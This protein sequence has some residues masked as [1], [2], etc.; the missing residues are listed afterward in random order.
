MPLRSQAIDANTSI[1]RH[2]YREDPSY[3]SG[4]GAGNTVVPGALGTAGGKQSA[5]QS[6]YPTV[7]SGSDGFLFL[8]EDF[9]NACERKMPVAE[10]LRRLHRLERMIVASGR[11]FVFTVA[12]DKSTIEAKYLP[13]HYVGRD[14]APEAKQA[15]WN[16]LERDPP[17]GY[18]DLRHALEGREEFFGTPIYTHLDTHWLSLGSTTFARQLAD[19]LDPALWG[20]SQVVPVPEGRSGGDLS[21]L[22]GE[23]REEAVAQFQLVRPGVTPAS[24]AQILLPGNTPVPIENSSTSAP[25]FAP[26]TLILGDS[27][28]ERSGAPAARLFAHA[29]GLRNSQTRSSVIA[30]E[31]PKADVIVLELVE[32]N[33]VGGAANIL[34]DDYLNAIE[35]ALARD[36]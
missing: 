15:F 7:V 28:F 26:Q 12:P 31:V 32:R 3:G 35:Q 10:T 16:A 22:L 4:G 9:K 17:D 5:N 2:L 13:S 30:R 34:Q 24:R 20:N 25:L 19:A 1:S 8:G 33:L 36:G 27:F 23:D 11:R 18:F 29:V 14:C 6:R 21:Q